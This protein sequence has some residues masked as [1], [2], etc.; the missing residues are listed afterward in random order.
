MGEGRRGPIFFLAGFAICKF[1]SGA[2]ASNPRDLRLVVRHQSRAP[3]DSRPIPVGVP[4]RG[5]RGR[6]RSD[7]DRDALVSISGRNFSGGVPI[8]T[9]RTTG[10]GPGVGPPVVARDEARHPA[11]NLSSE[12]AAARK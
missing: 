9:Q 11:P 1:V 4:A 6:P 3:T 8:G 7:C 2:P 10:S 12:P 5:Y